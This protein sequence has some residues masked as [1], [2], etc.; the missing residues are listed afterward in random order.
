MTGESCLYPSIMW[1]LGIELRA[2]RLGGKVPSPTEPSH[3]TE[4]VGAVRTIEA[5]GGSGQRVRW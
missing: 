3:Q 4:E 1:N 5:L 2:V